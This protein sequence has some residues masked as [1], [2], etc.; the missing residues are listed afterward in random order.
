MRI[1]ILRLIPGSRIVQTLLWLTILF[2]V[3][4]VINLW[5]M[6]LYTKILVYTGMMMIRLVTTLVYIRVMHVVL[7]MVI[8]LD[9]LD[10]EGVQRL[11]VESTGVEGASSILVLRAMLSAGKIRS[12][13]S[14]A[15]MYIMGMKELKMAS[16]YQTL[17][18]RINIGCLSGLI[19]TFFSIILTMYY[20]DMVTPLGA[21]TQL[22]PDLGVWAGHMLS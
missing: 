17:V 16:A 22:I 8:K 9:I 1:I 14:R 11:Q 6:R 12:M 13:W 7:L 15:L 5:M 10:M 2:M 20:G 18:L 3:H 19:L 21:H 4:L